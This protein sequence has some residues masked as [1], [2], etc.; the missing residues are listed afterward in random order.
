LFPIKI[1]AGSLQFNPLK[2]RGKLL[3]LDGEEI[4]KPIILLKRLAL[5]SQDGNVATV[6]AGKLQPFKKLVGH[7]II[8]ILNI[9]MTSRATKL[10]IICAFNCWNAYRKRLNIH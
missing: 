7:I 9:V 10:A 3:V 6:V 8:F 2:G 4:I 1:Y 5:A